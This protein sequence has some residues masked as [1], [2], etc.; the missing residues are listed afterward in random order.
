MPS[1]PW[2]HIQ[3]E[4]SIP[5]VRSWYEGIGRARRLVRYDGRGLGLSSRDVPEVSLESDVLDLAAVV[6]GLSLDSFDLYAGWHSGPAA[7]LYTTRH[8][9]RV[10]H[11]VLF[12]SYADGAAH[13]T[14]PLT[15]ATRP[16]IAQDWEYYSQLVAR[17]LLGWSE[18][19]AAEAFSDIVRQCTS[20]EFATRALAATSEFNV[21]H[22]L[23][24]VSVP[25]LVLHR[26]EQR[27]SSMDN[28]R[29]L[30]AGIPDVRLSLQPGESIAPYLGD[31]NAIVREIDAFLTGRQPTDAETRSDAAL[32]TSLPPGLE[33]SGG[34]STVVF[35]DVVASTELVEE[36]GDEAA[37]MALRSLED[38]TTETASRR[39][40]RVVKHLGD[41]SL[42][43]FAST[44]AALQFAAE[45]RAA[46]TEIGLKI[47][48]RVAV[49]EPIREDGDLHG[50]IVV[51]ASRITSAARSGE[52]L[53]SDAVRQLVQGKGFDFDDADSR[54]L[55]GFDEPVHLWR[56]RM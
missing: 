5:A 49:G 4:R 8:P 13:R 41:G 33:V 18:T 40:G 39:T 42:L 15:Q 3:L 20:P 36:L 6:D 19:E 1:L 44:S 37:R 26:P 22:L 55:K 52:V 51:L 25:T 45:L 21:S 7:N 32:T 34:I 43:E 53:V 2:S 23:E 24:E 56:L 12:C 50:S 35:T 11:L 9:E 30:A 31:T 14:N 47:A 27:T 46:S 54:R 38:A 10:G 48:I 16:I 28:A 29:A 17:L